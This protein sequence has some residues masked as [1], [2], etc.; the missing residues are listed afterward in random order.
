MGMYDNV[1]Y[2]CQ[3]PVCRS[4]KVTDFQ[5]KDADRILKNLKP[6]EVGNFYSACDVCGAFVQF[7]KQKDG[8][9]LRR[10]EKKGI[11]QKQYDKIVKIKY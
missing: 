2:E 3:C 9:W 1:I 10:V 7:Y 6:H 4:G 8:R 5:S 11:V